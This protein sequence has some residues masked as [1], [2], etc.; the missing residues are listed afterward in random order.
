MAYA[1][2]DYAGDGDSYCS[3]SGQVI[4]IVSSPVSWKSKLQDRNIS[5]TTKAKFVAVSSTI[6]NLLWLRDLPRQIG[7]PDSKSTPI[8]CDTEGVVEITTNDASAQRTM[9][10]GAQLFF[11]KAAR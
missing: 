3:T 6:K 10:I 4:S 2:A 8:F 9:H 7:L 1:D 5:A 11:A